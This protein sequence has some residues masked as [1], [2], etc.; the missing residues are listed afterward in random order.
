MGGSDNNITA[1]LCLKYFLF[2]SLLM[3]FKCKVL[4][5]VHPDSLICRCCDDPNTFC[6]LGVV[7]WVIGGGEYP[8]AHR[9]G[10]LQLKTVKGR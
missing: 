10:Q 1:T 5:E 3:R 6:I 2:Y 7:L 8:T 4:Q 9:L